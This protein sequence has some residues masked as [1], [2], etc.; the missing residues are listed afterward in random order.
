LT[1]NL[2]IDGSPALDAVIGEVS[3]WIAGN[4]LDRTLPGDTVTV[5]SAGKTAQVIYSDT[6]AGGDGTET[7]TQA[8][9]AI[10]AGGDSADGGF[11]PDFVGALRDASSRSR[12]MVYTLLI[13]ASPAALSS[14][15]L[16]EGANL[17]KFSR[18]EEFAGWRAMVIALNIDSRVRQAATEWL[19]AP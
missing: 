16:G 1:L 11:S 2:I 12:G 17:V 18:I 5:W 3:A 8:I 7:I 14:I 19:T 15:L 13:T 6:L 10:P 9:A 4:A